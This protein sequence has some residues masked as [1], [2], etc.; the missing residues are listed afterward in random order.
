MR[1]RRARFRPSPGDAPT[2]PHGYSL[3]APIEEYP[4]RAPYRLESTSSY[5]R[6]QSPGCIPSWSEGITQ[7]VQY[8][9]VRARYALVRADT[10]KIR[11]CTTP[12]DRVS[13]R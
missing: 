13:G 6:T 4:M 2:L 10:T 11:R 3:S 12:L 5:V 9:V 1:T 8:V 7:S